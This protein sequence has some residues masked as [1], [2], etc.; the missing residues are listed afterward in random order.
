MSTLL[1]T[2][3]EYV[4][5]DDKELE[6]WIENVLGVTDQ[7]VLIEET[8]FEVSDTAWSLLEFVYEAGIAL[9]AALGDVTDLVEK[10]RQ[11]S[12]QPL[13]SQPPLED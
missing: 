13:R 9:L 4:D 7:L 1:I 3:L 5:D 12:R 8:V 11:L 10:R 6:A 2:I